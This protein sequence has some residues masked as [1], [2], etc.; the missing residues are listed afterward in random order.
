M[1]GAP[2]RVC[3]K[4]QPESPAVAVGKFL[5]LGGYV[6]RSLSNLQTN[7]QTAITWVTT[8]TTEATAIA[9]SVPTIHSQSTHSQSTRRRCTVAQST[10][11]NHISLY[12]LRNRTTEIAGDMAEIA[13]AEIA[14]ED[15]VVA[16]GRLLQFCAAVG[17][18]TRKT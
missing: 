11:S 4:A 8:I 2:H 1:F 5:C 3:A 10:F 15:Q 9:K 12:M 18:S 7:S 13:G 17:C 14:A 6:F 16:S